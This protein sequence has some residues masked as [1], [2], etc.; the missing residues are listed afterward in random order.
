[1]IKVFKNSNINFKKLEHKGGANFFMSP[2]QATLNRDD[3]D[4]SR[5]IT[6]KHITTTQSF[7]NK[8]TAAF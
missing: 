7:Q 2:Q 5:A 4:H 6:K 3:F 1:M 8:L